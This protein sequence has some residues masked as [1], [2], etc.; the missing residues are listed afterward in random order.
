MTHVTG[1]Q[2]SPYGEIRSE[3]RVTDG[4]ARLSYEAVVPAN[5]E[6]TLHLPAVSADS[7]REGRSPLARVDGVRCLGH[8]DGVASYRLPSGSYRLT[9]RLR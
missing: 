4:S 3:W 5:S 1:S 8:T 2:V 9:S 6:A 7:V